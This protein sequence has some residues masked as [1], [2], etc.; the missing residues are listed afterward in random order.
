M[1]RKGFTFPFIGFE[2]SFKEENGLGRG[3]QLK[4]KKDVKFF[5]IMVFNF[6]QTKGY[7]HQRQFYLNTKN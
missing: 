6:I 7:M 5:L 4:N 3:E 1:E 2:C